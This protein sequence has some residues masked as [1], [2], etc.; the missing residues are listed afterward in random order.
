MRIR[1]RFQ[2][3]KVAISAALPLDASRPASCS[4]LFD[5]ETVSANSQ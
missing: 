4:T 1:I 5:H 3:Q 2:L